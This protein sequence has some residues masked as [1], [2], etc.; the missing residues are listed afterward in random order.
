MKQIHIIRNIPKFN[1]RIIHIETKCD[2]NMALNV[3]SIKL[4]YI[5]EG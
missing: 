4:N 2:K 3:E 1:R 5:D